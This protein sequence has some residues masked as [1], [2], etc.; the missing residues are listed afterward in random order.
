MCNALEFHQNLPRKEVFAG[1]VDTGFSQKSDQESVGY[2]KI[3]N[4]LMNDFI[5]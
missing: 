1:M 5:I 3:I 2:E 4:L